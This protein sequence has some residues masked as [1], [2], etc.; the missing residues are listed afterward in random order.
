MGES[1]EKMQERAFTQAQRATYQQELS[2]N[3]EKFASVIGTT[4]VRWV[5]PFVRTTLNIAR[6]TANRM[7][8]VNLIAPIMDKI[9]P[10]I[11]RQA[12]LVADNMIVKD[13][14]AGG[15]RAQAAIG[16]LTLTNG[17]FMGIMMMKTEGRITGGG[18]LPMPNEKR[19][20][21]EPYT[22]YLPGGYRFSYQNNP[23]LK[24]MIGIPVTI[25]EIF[26]Q[27]DWESDKASEDAEGMVNALAMLYGNMLIN[28]TFFNS[29]AR[30]IN[31]VQ[32][33]ANNGSVAYFN[34]EVKRIVVSVTP[35]SGLFKT[36]Q[37][38]IDPTVRDADGIL[39]RYKNAY[40]IG[41][42]NPVAIDLFGNR[43][44]NSFDG[45]INGLNM[46][47]NDPLT[48]ELRR[49]RPNIPD[50]PRVDDSPMTPFEKKEFSLEER[51]FM[52]RYIADGQGMGGVPFKSAIVETIASPDYRMGDYEYKRTLIEHVANKYIDN[53]VLALKFQRQTGMTP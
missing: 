3:L 32:A 41:T 52:R 21:Y 7:P 39:D 30:L 14:R 45:S 9:G 20:P 42:E 49:I 28:D 47:G 23:V 53:A 16:S 10:D 48:L 8:G 5:V 34:N 27:I 15:A 18:G 24:A 38:I 13:L 50:V 25:K 22:I 6:M 44:Y 11:L 46:S 29:F 2:G 31:G 51:A 17:V 37:R 35:G 19:T 40:G 36:V 33:W 4:P 1:L 43:R 26:H 12:P